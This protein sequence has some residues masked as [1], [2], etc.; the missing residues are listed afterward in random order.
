MKTMSWNRGYFLRD[1]SDWSNCT[2][3]H[4]ITWQ[5]HKMRSLVLIL[6]TLHLVTSEHDFKII[7]H[8]GTTKDTEE[9]LSC[10]RTCI[11]A[12]PNNWWDSSKHP[13]TVYTRVQ[14]DECGFVALPIITATLVTP[15]NTGLT[16]GYVRGPSDGKIQSFYVYT[17]NTGLTAAEINERGWRVH[18]SATGFTCFWTGDQYIV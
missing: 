9:L 13:G 6:L 14:M 17:D 5:P 16:G 4:V 2:A 3:P 15:Y 10:P 12:G 18:W 8:P 1:L 11:G 7:S